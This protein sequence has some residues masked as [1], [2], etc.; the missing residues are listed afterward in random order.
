MADTTD[1]ITTTIAQIEK[2]KEDVD[3]ERRIVSALPPVH[4]RCEE[5][6]LKAQHCKLLAEK[7]ELYELTREEQRIATIARLQEQL[8]PPTTDDSG[9]ECPICLDTID[10]Q[11]LDTTT[12]L[13]C[14]GH[15]LCLECTEANASQSE[16]NKMRSCPLCRAPFPRDAEEMNRKVEILAERGNPM[17]QAKVGDWYM[18]GVNG[19][20]VNYA[21]AHQMLE[22]S[23]ENRNALSLMLLATAHMK[24]SGVPQSK[25]KAMMYMKKSADVGY[26]VAQHILAV[27][28]YLKAGGKANQRQAVFYT[29]LAYHNKHDGNKSSR[30]GSVSSQLGYWFY[31]GSCG[32]TKSLILAKHYLEQSAAKGFERSYYLLAKTLCELTKL[33]YKDMPKDIPGYCA[34]PMIIHWA[35]KA[36]TSRDANRLNAA[37][38]VAE[39]EADSKQTCAMCCGKAKS[40]PKPMKRCMRCKAVWYCGRKCAMKHGKQGH[41]KDCIPVGLK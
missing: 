3:A 1:T 18:K 7:E 17:A 33:Q 40:F 23:A 5:A 39:M 27:Q 28:F 20:P 19:R 10:L 38:L 16:E 13:V 9:H 11:G 25:S 26:A 41:Q 24:G 32:L 4:T 37:S 14:C 30:F 6:T 2:L 34:T 22:R 8:H 29:T 31:H 36:A 35:R 15:F 12:I 21:K